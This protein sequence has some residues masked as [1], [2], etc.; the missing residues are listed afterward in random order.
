M[1]KDLQQFLK[2][3]K[4]KAWREATRSE[5]FYYDGLENLFTR[6]HPGKMWVKVS[7]ISLLVPDVKLFR[8]IPTRR[9]HVLA[10]FRP[11][12]YIGLSVEVKGVH[13]TR[14]Y[15]LVSSPNQLAYYEIA[16]RKK[17]RGFVSPYLFDT[18]K[19]GDEF[20]I[21]EPM[22]N[23]YYNSLF[24]GDNLVFIAGGCGVTPFIAMLRDITERKLPLNVWLLFGCVKEE[25]ILFRQEL[26]DIQ[27]RR[28]NIHVQCILSEPGAGWT[29]LKG[30]ISKD[31]ISQVVGSIEKN[32]FYIVGN[33]PMYQ[34]VLPQLA[35]LGIPRHR[36]IHE[37]YGMPDTVKEEPGWPIDVS[38]DKKV[39]VSIEYAGM[40]K[41][42]E[43]ACGEPLLNGIERAH[44]LGLQVNSGC[45]S[46][47]C[48]LCRTKLLSGNVFVPAEVMVREADK[49]NNF[50]HPC[51][52]YPL[53]DLRI[54]LLG[55]E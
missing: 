14:P 16:I 24:H 47:E 33:R 49:A 3:K 53:S 40:E 7:D 13:S 4:M 18:V 39:T 9:T 26:E 29:G 15:S 35:E 22:G 46:G 25:D 12:Q 45:R 42:I 36:V 44:L 6:L 31:K 28:P 50:I 10:P 38:L 55:G 41:T 48:G 17:I 34:F 19:E 27:A 11:G 54:E 21:T 1:F 30:F 8:L 20:E 5:I 23:F 2:A 52:S 51:A 43:V 37:A 32:F